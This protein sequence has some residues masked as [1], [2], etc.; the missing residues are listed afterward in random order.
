MVKSIVL[1][2]NKLSGKLVKL[3]IATS[4][5]ALLVLVNTSISQA[6]TFCD[7][8]PENN[9]ASIDEAISSC[10]DGTT[11]RFPENA[12]Y[13]L[14]DTIFVKDR[15][16]LVI[17]GRGS[18]FTI[19]TEGDTKPYL[20]DGVSRNGGNWLILRGT[21][22]TLRNIISVGSFPLGAKP[23]VEGQTRDIAKQNEPGVV[24]GYA[25]YMSNFG[26]YGVNGVYLEDLQGWSPWGDVVTS[27]PDTY[28]D[29]STADYTNNVFIKRVQSV[30]SSRHCWALTSG[31]N[32]WIED[33]VCRD[34]WYIGTDQEIDNLDQPLIG[35]HI[36][37]NTFDGY[38]LGGITV[39]VAGVETRDIEIIG[40]IFL[41]PVDLPRT[42]NSVIGIGGWPENPNVF[43]NVT[44]RNNTIPAYDGS[45]A[46]QLDNIKNGLVKDNKITSAP[47][48][49]CSNEPPKVTVT[50]STE[51]TVENNGPDAPGADGSTSQPA[52]KLPTVSLTSPSDGA[53]VSGT[54]DVAATASDDNGVSKV[55]F[56][57]NGSVAS[58]DTTTPY[59]FSW[60][61][62]GLS[63]N[64]TLSAK[65]TDT[66][67]QAV[68]SSSVTVNVNNEEAPAPT[69]LAPTNFAGTP[70]PEGSNRYDFTWSSVSGATGYD[71][72]YAIA[73]D[74]PAHLY[75][76]TFTATSASAY[77]LPATTQYNFAVR[78]ICGSTG[79]SDNSNVVAVNQDSTVDTTPPTAPTNLSA[80]AVG[81][82]QVDLSWGASTDN[83]EVSK[84][85][86]LRNGVNLAEVSA[87][88]TSY[89]DT[90]ASA[91]I[92]YEYAVKAI[93]TSNNTSDS[94][95][96][97]NVTTP[98][99]ADTSK[100]SAP[101]NL[102]G[103][104]PS[105][106]QINLSWTASTDD[107][108][109]SA[110]TINRDGTD[111]ATLDCSSG[112]CSSS[113][114]TFGDSGL[115]AST[116]YSYSVTA[117][118]AAGNVSDP[119]S[120]SVTTQA[121][122]P[123]CPAPTNFAGTPGPSGTN[124]YDFT[125]TASDNATGYDL[126]YAIAPGEPAY[127]YSGTFTGTSA[128]AYGLNSSTEYNFSVRAKC[129]SSEQS[130]NSNVLL[131]STQ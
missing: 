33:S 3:M 44:I 72:Y 123:T 50:D 76:G 10:A 12:S 17:D 92:T 60:D 47:G 21:N 39:P 41:T 59:N 91:G 131:V 110:Y 53:Q 106:S 120:T 104:S 111:I 18:T 80:N 55:E 16:N 67:N 54:V 4:A 87:G 70:G 34:A 58:T 37:R 99:P 25:E 65:A 14:P 19:T 7:I 88:T 127:L 121:P 51:M 29:G 93:D 2:K 46:I 13:S 113:P 89:S 15:H 30:S 95:N 96:S 85:L 8:N 94:S 6:E 83:V 61:T 62:T 66:A 69:C 71:L 128:S 32:I 68:T 79:T 114:I 119:S 63:G 28:V 38:G 82:T 117:R 52:D 118:D 73:P 11:V 122:A 49:S 24:E 78:A 5:L 9:N 64:Y 48:G 86:V 124:R 112:A 56:L 57:I 77:G 105:N 1:L 42:C 116:S 98:S 45:P 101:A 107:V 84:Y 100:P 26:L 102:S 103:T 22:I 35:L 115:N 97:V 23:G 81:P 36:L 130:T 108:G 31:S 27:G 129:G 90:N 43:E 125:W 109:V 75:S 40:N 20:P 126:Y 74:E